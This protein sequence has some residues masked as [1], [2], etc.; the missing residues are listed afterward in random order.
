MRV[1]LARG[2]LQ[3]PAALRCALLSRG[4]HCSGRLAKGIPTWAVAASS[5]LSG[6]HMCVHGINFSRGDRAPISSVHE[7]ARECSTS[8][9]VHGRRG[10]MTP[11]RAFSFSLLSTPAPTPNVAVPF[12]RRYAGRPAD[13]TLSCSCTWRRP[14]NDDLEPYSSN[15]REIF[16]QVAGADRAGHSNVGN[17]IPSFAQMNNKGSDWVVARLKKLCNGHV[18][19]CAY[20]DW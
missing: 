8:S 10:S 3:S 2:V 18:A 1:R 19:G 20:N 4:Q 13:A 12:G 14:I 15:V 9:G 6:V 5:G 17:Q 16:T 7:N 11:T